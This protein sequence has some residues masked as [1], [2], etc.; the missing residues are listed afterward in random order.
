M[1]TISLLT[2]LAL[3][4]LASLTA[5]AGPST[6]HPTRPT[7]P[8]ITVACGDANLRVAPAD[9]KADG[10]RVILNAVSVPPAYI[11]QVQRTTVEGWAY[12]TK[13]GIEIEA[14]SP[15]VRISVPKAWQKRAAIEWGLGGPVRAQRFAACSPPPT[16]WNGF[17]GGFFLSD[18]SACVPLLIQVGKR[19]ATVRFGIGRRCSAS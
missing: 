12:W 2:L 1:R 16:Y 8:E 17:V 9:V 7:E 5:A 13:T 3:A 15:V 11:R 19:T 18:R 14:G 6:A 10:R 4:A